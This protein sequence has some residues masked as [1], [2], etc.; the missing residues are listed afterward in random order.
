[1]S[2]RKKVCFQLLE[3]CC[4]SPTGSVTMA[5]SRVGLNPEVEN[6]VHLWSITP[7]GFI[8]YT[9][10]PDLVLEVKGQHPHVAWHDSLGCF[11]LIVHS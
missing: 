7:Q 5:G 11:D 10:T 4:L 8:C 6:Q 9:P 3:E 1:M 2:L